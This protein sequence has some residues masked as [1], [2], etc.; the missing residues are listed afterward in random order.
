MVVVYKA[1]KKKKMSV[2]G[3]GD[4]KEGIENVCLF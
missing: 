2:P 1:E 3:T 4:R